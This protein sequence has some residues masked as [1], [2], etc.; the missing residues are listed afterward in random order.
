[1]AVIRASQASAL[2]GE[3]IVLDL[4]DLARQGERIKAQARARAEQ[5]IERAQVQARR[6]VAGGDE[7]GYAKGLARGLADG[8]EQGRTEA[9][10]EAIEG[11]R[12]RLDRLLS[13][14]ESALEQFE[15]ERER[16]LIEARTDVLELAMR[17]AERVTR[18][19]ART[20]PGVVA[21]QISAVLAL[22]AGETALRIAVCPDDE[23]SAADCLPAL[24]ARLDSSTHADVVVDDRLEPGS[25][26]VRSASGGRIDASIGTQ[27]D[28]IAEALIPDRGGD[29]DPPASGR[30]GGA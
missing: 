15:R 30:G 24:L 7:R 5:I 23:R 6:I 4:G 16:M 28:R 14:W 17:I 10:D 1:M 22:V 21:E 27:L 9:H 18:R 11:E 12:E 19:T 25:C 2:A 8:A 13:S 3:A 20:D 29:G 26:V